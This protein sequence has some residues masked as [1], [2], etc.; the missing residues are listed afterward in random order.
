MDP[1]GP[2]T[3]LELSAEFQARKRWREFG[4]VFLE[5]ERVGPWFD[6]WPLTE[7]TARIIG[8]Q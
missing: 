7:R 4:R 1:G 2:L 6:F 5:L 3:A 8:T